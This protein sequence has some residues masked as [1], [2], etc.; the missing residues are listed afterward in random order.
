[1][2][3]TRFYFS[4]AVGSVDFVP[5]SYVYLHW[6]GVPLTSVEF[7]ALYV[8][9]R[10]LLERHKLQAILADHHAMPA[11]PEEADKTWLLQQWLPATVAATALTRYAVLPT[12]EPGHRLHTETVL[13]GLR[14]QLQVGIFDD[15][16]AASSWL[17]AA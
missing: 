17:T 6:S 2:V 13:E 8:H 5:R 11:A 3:P 15:L 7:R 14:R 4:N 12:P 16:Q 9:V 10:N 1:M